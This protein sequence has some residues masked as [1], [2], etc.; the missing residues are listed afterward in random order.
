M[1]SERG[2]ERDSTTVDAMVFVSRFGSHFGSVGRREPE[3]ERKTFRNSFVVD[4]LPRRATPKGEQRGEQ[5]VRGATRLPGLLIT[6]HVTACSGAASAELWI[7]SSANK[8]NLTCDGFLM[9]ETKPNPANHQSPR[10]DS[11]QSLP[12]YKHSIVEQTLGD[13]SISISRR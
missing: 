1:H 2:D 3:R 4:T 11:L 9:L 8:H 10:S 7:H 6:V 5:R 12:R 13:D